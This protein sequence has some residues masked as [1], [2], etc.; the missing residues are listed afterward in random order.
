MC[1]GGVLCRRTAKFLSLISAGQFHFRYLH[2]PPTLSP[3][4]RS[5]LGLSSFLRSSPRTGKH[6]VTLSRLLNTTT[7]SGSE[8]RS[9]DGNAKSTDLPV[10]NPKKVAVLTKM[11]RYDYEKRLHCYWTEEELESYLTERGSDYA[12]LK[13][14]HDAHHGKV[15]EVINALRERGIEVRLVERFQYTPSLIKWADAIITAGGD[16]TYLLGASKIQTTDIPFLGVNTDLLRSEGYLCLPRYYSQHFTEA[17]DRLLSGQFKWVYRQRIRITMRGK[18][19]NDQGIELHDEPL[20]SPEHRFCEHI[21]EHEQT[22]VNVDENQPDRVLP[23]LALNEV[24]LGESLSARVSYYEISVDGS[25]REKQK[26]SGVT[27]CTGTGSSSWYFNI[28]HL[29]KNS[30][31]KLLQ[32]ANEV[33]D[34]KIPDDDEGFVKR[35]TKLYNRHLRFDAGLPQVAYTVRDPV[36][37]GIFQVSN[38]H[39]LAKRVLIKSRMWDAKL[40]VDGGVSFRFNDG[41]IASLEIFKEDALRTVDFDDTP[42]Y[43]ADHILDPD[44]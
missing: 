39:G 7:V 9:D 41:A 21:R 26:S 18:H 4:P 8:R 25:P 14:M 19:Q 33:G 42:A 3:L 30:I 43:E 44:L 23:I 17:L 35:V 16:G 37:N 15:R 20:L 1:T 40:V 29:H 5:R 38:P 27:V 10:F 22:Y 11:T 32:I 24:F 13:R 36:V 12:G 28:N 6:A 31:R 34:L 2:T